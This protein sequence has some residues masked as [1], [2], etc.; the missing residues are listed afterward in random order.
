MLEMRVRG[1]SPATSNARRDTVSGDDEQSVPLR[2]N[3]KRYRS[4][5]ML[6]PWRVRLTRELRVRWS[7]LSRYSRGVLMIFLPLFFMH[8]SLGTI[9]HFFH[10]YGSKED[11]SAPAS[12]TEPG[13]AV[14]INTYKRPERLAEAI[15]HYADTCG[16]RVGI[17]HIFIIWAE[18]DVTPPETSSFFTSSLKNGRPIKNRS[19]VEIIRVE[20]DSL[21]SRF[22]PLANL[23]SKSIFMVDDDI[24]VDCFSLYQGFTAWKG[25]P[26]AMVGYYPRLAA[27][28]RG[29]SK[30]SHE[31][32]YYS[33]PTVFWRHQMNFVL[34]KACF[35]HERYMELYSS[36]AHPQ[37]IKDYV[38][39]YFNC[40]DVAMS[41]L[42]A[43]YTR[44]ETG[45]AAVPIYVEG[46][47]SDSGL[48]GGISTGG[49]HMNQ[50]SKCVTDLTRIYEQHGWKPPLDE[51]TNLL[52]ASWVHHAPGL[53]WQYR[54][55]NIFEWFAL[56]NIFK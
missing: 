9:D 49:G 44:S 3:E 55:S 41:L 14:V 48:F 23:Q 19:T 8:L 2:G 18:E 12:S 38:D 22:L 53:W 35:L 33:W 45:K 50:R 34:S 51:P 26:D 15:R 11:S 28:G 5:M 29:Q 32:V 54:P 7:L 16:R 52:A 47:V 6:S 56:E 25:D 27:P 24:R 13:F 39:K 30:E 21:N 17:D 40:E 36:A 37:A 10:Y 31:Y 42:V 43:N 1:H 4:N 20:K 46:S